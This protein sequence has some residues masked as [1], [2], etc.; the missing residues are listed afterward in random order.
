MTAQRPNRLEIG[1]KP[2][3]ADARGEH[4]AHS[5]AKHLGYPSLRVRTRDILIFDVAL[6]PSE[7]EAVAREFTD[8]VIQ[9]SAAPR[10]EPGEAFDWMVIVG[11]KPGV[12]DNVG[13]TARA[14][15]VDILGRQLEKD[16]AVYTATSYLISGGNLTRKQAENLGRDLLANTLIETIEVISPEEWRA[17]RPEIRVPKV[18]GKFERRVERVD[19]AV[20]DEELQKIS[21][22][23]TLSLSLVEMQ[24]IRDHFAS[25]AVQAERRAAGLDGRPTDVELE[26][27]AQTWSEHCKHKI[28]NALIDFEDE[29]GSRRTIDSLF[30][31]YVRG[32]TTEV[33]KRRPWLVSVF[34]DNAGVIAFNDRMDLVYKVE[35]HNSPSALEPYGGA[36]TGIV[37]CNRDP[38][39]TGL[40]AELLINVWGYCFASPE[41]DDSAVPEGMMHPR[42]LRDGVHKG[43]IDG[44]N[45]S[46]IPY[47][48]G[49]EFFDPRYM[50]KPLV[51][52]G[53][54]GIMPKTVPDG[55]PASVKSPKPGD[56]IVMT[57]GRIGKDGIHGA[58][59]SSEELHADSPVQAVQIGDPITQKKMSDWLIEARDLGLYSAVTDNGAGGLSSSV[60]EMAD[61]TG[62]ADVDLSSA[63]LKYEGLQPWEIWLSEAQER[64]T[65][66]VPPDKIEALKELAKRRDVELSVLGTF[67]TSGRLTL[68]HGGEVVALIDMQFLHEGDPRYQLRAKW[69]RPQFDRPAMPK[70]SD[71]TGE[72][73][74]LLMRLNLA[75]DETKARQYDH[76]VKGRT[77][78]KPWVGAERDVPSDATVFIAEYGGTEGIVLSAG[79]NSHLGDLDCYNM[80]GWVIDEAIRRIIAVGGRFDYIAG[81]DNF[82]WP[83]PV[84]SAST[85]DGAYKLAQLV[86]ANQGLYD[87]C[88]AFGVP[89][90]SGKDSM[91]NDSS[92][93]GRKISIPPSVLFSAIGRIDDIGKAV[94]LEAKRPGDLVY[95]IGQT[96]SELGGSEYAWMASERAGRGW[97]DGP[98]I[99]GKAP[100]VDAGSVWKIYEA[101]ESAVKAG[102][103]RSLHAP[104]LGGLAAGFA[105]VAMG[106]ELGLA[107]ELEAI[108]TGE[109]MNETECLFSESAGRFI[110]TV[111]PEN[112][113]EFEAIF[114]GLPLGRVGVVSEEP[115]LL[116]TAHGGQPIVRLDLKE[117]K[118]AWK[119]AL[120]EE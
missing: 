78:V 73:L 99:G 112:A 37:G 68:R 16:E 51:Y 71:L 13:R 76:E 69:R 96:R 98:T 55:R 29:D 108:P 32:A 27:L 90:I 67:T 7:L 81:L 93:G 23:R 34:H 120:A 63:P 1:L 87:Y 47:G 70:G 115:Y 5:A 4:V 8:P 103:V 62:G 80:M 10:L 65:L 54:L 11:F 61:M 36:M 106:G 110:A 64:M 58:T 86:R 52:C 24:T 53:T 84:E 109:G 116:V 3:V 83:D 105:K 91:K 26:M 31:T 28:F 15:L 43:V 46:G 75:S 85:P 9:E 33:A 18:T 6:E 94:T 100:S 117:A 57:G 22:S 77:V 45:Q 19:L 17:G 49:W 101:T 95:V 66:A 72:L 48:V 102:L 60:G 40:G 12:T 39:G 21:S 114:N 35:T 82:C 25:E 119:S 56:L 38:L 97:D 79:F 113:K 111:D 89:L 20:S 118:A 42:R 92:R 104:A 2:G 59:F 88:V 14:A 107:V 30:K 41:T 44:G 50:A 74:A